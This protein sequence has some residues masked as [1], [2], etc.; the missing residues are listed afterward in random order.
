MFQL[1]A[2]LT[3]PFDVVKTL[4]QIEITEKEIITG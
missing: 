2:A 3:T 1:A 4:R